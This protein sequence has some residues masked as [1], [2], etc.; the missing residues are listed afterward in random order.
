MFSFSK[1]SNLSEAISVKKQNYSWGKMITVHH[2][3]DT[4]YPLHPEHQAKIKALNNGE[5]TSF[6]DETKR[7]VTAH[8]SGDTIHLSGAGTSKK[9]AVDRSHFAEEVEQE[10]LS[11]ETIKIAEASDLAKQIDELSRS[12]LSSYISKASDARKHKGMP[13]SKVDKRYTG[14]AKASSRLDKKVN[15]ATSA[16][17]RINNRFKKLSGRSLGTAAKEYGDEVKDLQKKIEA[18]KAE[19]ERRQAALK[20][21]HFTRVD[22]TKS[23]PRG[24]HFTSDG[25]LKR[26]DADVDGDGGK[27]LRSDPLDK[28]RNKIP[29]VSEEN[30]SNLSS[31]IK[32]KLSDE[33]GAA[34]FKV[35]KDAAKKINVNLTPEMLKGMSG[36]KLHRDGDYILEDINEVTPS[37]HQVKQ[38]I[39]IARDK[40]YAKGNV[41]GAVRAMDKLNPGLAQHPAVK[42]E[43]RKQNEE[44]GK[45]DLPFTPD[46]PKAP[47]AM[48]GKYGLGYS[49]AKHLAR[50][51]LSQ[52]LKKKQNK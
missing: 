29:S 32:S 16:Y 28:T 27:K 48:A 3:S 13:T 52:Q 37:S 8:R 6:K 15:E 34:A 24:F 42:K 17:S 23:A 43:L 26:G 41:S 21:E 36:I 39:G 44:K 22:E 38:A 31:V 20:K 49:T 18:Q 5:K 9:T 46:K 10:E 25:R 19:N 4:S 2:G 47:N 33:G 12:T 30:N 50:M 35:L 1:Y 11:L 40:R 7:T 51:A 45:D 14:V